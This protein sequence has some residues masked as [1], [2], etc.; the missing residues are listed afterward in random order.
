MSHDYHEGHPN[1][2]KFQLFYDGC[3]E[4]KMR[5]E[6]PVWSVE[7]LKDFRAA[8]MRAIRFEKGQLEPSEAVS[9]TEVPVLRTL[10]ALVVQF[11]RIGYP[12]GVFPGD[13]TQ[14]AIGVGHSQRRYL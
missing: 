14:I 13:V 10:W 2:N 5:A 8:W 4:C 6:H 3:T 9:N 11:E 12:I 1:Y 7:Y